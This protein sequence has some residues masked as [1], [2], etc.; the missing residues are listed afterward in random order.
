MP[1]ELIQLTTDPIRKIP[2]EILL[3]RM[4]ENF[5][6][7]DH[8]E[9]SFTLDH[10]AADKIL[11]EF[12]SRG[13]DLVIDYEH[14]TLSGGKAPAAGWIQSLEIRSDGLWGI[15]KYWSN[16]AKEFLEKGEYRYFSPT[17][18]FQEGKPCALHS[19]ALTNHPALH[20]IDALVAHDL[21]PSGSPDTNN[22]GGSMAEE[23]KQIALTDDPI[24][25]VAREVLGLADA[26][27]E[28]V[29]GKLLALKTLAEQA[30]SLQEQL[31]A[32]TDAA[33][34][35]KKSSLLADL[36]S[37]G[38]L[39]NAMAASDYF[40]SL[41]LSELQA[42]ADATPAGSVVPVGLT[43]AGAKKR[44]ADK[45]SGKLTPLQKRLGLTEEDLDKFGKQITEE[46]EDD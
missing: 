28:N 21:N 34:A 39:S 7:K 45:G 32:L 23:E 43:D 15:V 2:Q 1:E 12:D 25:S 3:I 20:H 35:E 41:S 5:Y 13:R 37:Q 33:N 46:G 6:T 27:V 38:K 44:A 17:I 42:Y 40:Q 26:T 11:Q 36:C 19:V 10:N 24:V 30:Q 18:L 29:R 9:G 8:K 31:K 14:Q 16:E 4:G 22:K